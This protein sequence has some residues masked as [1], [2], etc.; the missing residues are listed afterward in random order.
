M[1]SVGTA[2]TAHGTTTPDLASWTLALLLP[3]AAAAGYAAGWVAL[4]RRGAG[5]P[6]WRRLA[7]AGAVV[8]AAVASSP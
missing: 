3:A 8:C 1:S 5:W 2:L 4:T 6:A 7:A